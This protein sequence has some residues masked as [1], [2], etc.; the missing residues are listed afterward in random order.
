MF[1]INILE[2]HNTNNITVCINTYN[3]SSQY[4][5][6]NTLCG[7]FDVNTLT[8]ATLYDAPQTSITT[9]VGNSVG[10]AKITSYNKNEDGTFNV[11]YSVV[12]LGSGKKISDVKSI[13]NSTYGY[14]NL[15]YSINFFIL[16]LRF[17]IYPRTKSLKAPNRV[18]ICYGDSLI[19]ISLEFLLFYNFSNFVIK[20]IFNIL[21]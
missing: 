8:N 11:Y 16:L 18:A 15:K 10:V 4:F 13:R 5:V 20:I 1:T 17:A 14:V 6:A 7:Y 2:L 3:E 12:N 9:I 19:F 21:K